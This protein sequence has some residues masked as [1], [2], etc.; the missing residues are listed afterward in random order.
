TARYTFL[1]E[2]A[3]KVG[4]GCVAT[5]HHANDQA[6]TVLL[7]LIRGSGMRG[8]AGLRPV[9]LYPLPEYQSLTLIRPLLGIT[10]V[11]IERYCVEQSIPYRHDATNDVPN[12]LRNR[13]RL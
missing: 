13:I 7:H 4:A 10:R 2:V 12:S 9:A 1:A 3:Q 6:E 11:E 5:G 8:L